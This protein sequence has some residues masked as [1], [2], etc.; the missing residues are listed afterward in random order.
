[1]GGQSYEDQSTNSDM[2]LYQNTNGSTN[3]DQFKYN[4]NGGTWNPRDL[5]K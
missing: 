1:M 3:A 4:S 2:A 5:G